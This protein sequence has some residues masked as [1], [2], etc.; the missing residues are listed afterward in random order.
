[1]QGITVATILKEMGCNTAVITAMQDATDE[2]SIGMEYLGRWTDAPAKYN[3]PQNVAFWYVSK[4]PECGFKND[5]ETEIANLVQCTGYCANGITELRDKVENAQE[6]ADKP[7][8]S[9]RITLI[10]SQLFR[11]RSL[12]F[13]LRLML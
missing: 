6:T 7:S 1:M 8:P 5:F 2:P 13:I 3:E 10:R 11:A 4:R 9:R 12:K